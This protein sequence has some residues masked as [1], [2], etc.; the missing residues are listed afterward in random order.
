MSLEYQATGTVRTEAPNSRARTR[1]ATNLK[2]LHVGRHS[3]FCCES[4]FG[5]HNAPLCEFHW[6]TRHCGWAGG[7]T[8]RTSQWNGNVFSSVQQ[9]RQQLLKRA[10]G[11]A[12]PSEPGA[13]LPHVARSC[14][15]GRRDRAIVADGCRWAKAEQQRGA[16][17]A[18]S[19]R[20]TRSRHDAK[21]RNSSNAPVAAPASPLPVSWR[22]IEMSW[23]ILLLDPAYSSINLGTKA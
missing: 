19:E 3:S 10:S 6:I 22:I 1:G 14:Y 20:A 2:S 17:D 16:A 23:S 5:H 18:H 12:D 4:G 13:N 11:G 21:Q 8:R 9:R 15:R 7:W